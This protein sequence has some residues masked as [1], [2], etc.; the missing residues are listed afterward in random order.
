MALAFYTDATS[1]VDSR[2]LTWNPSWSTNDVL[3]CLAATWD[4]ANT[5]GTPSGGS[6]SWTLQNTIGSGFGVFMYVWTCVPGSG[7]SAT[8]TSA[9]AGG[10]NVHT[11]ELIVCPTADGY[12]LAGTPVQ[13]D[14]GDAGSGIAGST[15]SINITGSAGSVFFGIA[16]DVN[17]TNWTTRSWNLSGTEDYYVFSNGNSTQATVHGSLTGGTDAFGLTGLPSGAQ[18]RL[19]VIEVLY[20]PPPTV[21]TGLVGAD[22]KGILTESGLWLA[23]G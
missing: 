21:F 4:G 22:S 5:Q 3:V 10:N 18:T 23:T 8:I 12:S 13:A 15:P 14:S 20:N 16:G 17:G 9:S 6:L 1:A 7:G 19:A 11:G 2:S